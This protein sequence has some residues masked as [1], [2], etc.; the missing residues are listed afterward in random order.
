MKRRTCR[1]S[2]RR[3]PRPAEL[4][5][6]I[7]RGEARKYAKYPTRFIYLPAAYVRHVRKRG[8]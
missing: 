1:R 2:K 3:V 6:Q 4:K 8:A 7:L 5:Q